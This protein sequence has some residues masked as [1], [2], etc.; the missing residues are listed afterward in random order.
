MILRIRIPK[1]SSSTGIMSVGFD[2]VL[3]CQILQFEVEGDFAWHRP[4][5]RACDRTI[6][7][8]G[9][10]ELLDVCLMVDDPEDPML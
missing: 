1:G 6:P 5:R 2:S 4:L 10:A 9:R 7:G 3:G 8:A